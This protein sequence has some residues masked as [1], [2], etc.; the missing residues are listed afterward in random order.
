MSI[1]VCIIIVTIIINTVFVS[2]AQGLPVRVG[3]YDGCTRP[4]HPTLP[5]TTATTTATTTTTLRLFII[6][7][8]NDHYA[9]LRT[10]D[11]MDT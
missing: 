11:Y 4:T 8:N 5:S 7:S 6:I 2:S 9:G 10:R 3:E 1:R